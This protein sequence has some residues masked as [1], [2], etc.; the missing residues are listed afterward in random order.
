M[1]A[2]GDEPR[3]CAALS[4]SADDVARF[5]RDMYGRRAIGLAEALGIQQPHA[6]LAA[7]ADDHEAAVCCIAAHPLVRRGVDDLRR[8]FGDADLGVTAERPEPAADAVVAGGR[9]VEDRDSGDALP[10]DI[11]MSV[12]RVQPIDREF[13]DGA[14]GAERGNFASRPFGPG[15]IRRGS[16]AVP[17]L[18]VPTR[19]ATRRHALPPVHQSTTSRSRKNSASYFELSAIIG[20]A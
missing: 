15:R 8:P 10:V 7:S 17:A 2:G 12:G 4:G 3:R 13:L 16:G 20:E 11:E 5:A 18:P 6:R 14:R 9:R 19:P 1:P